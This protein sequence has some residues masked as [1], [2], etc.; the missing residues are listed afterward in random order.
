MIGIMF[1]FL[2]ALITGISL[3]LQKVSLIKINNWKQAITSPKWLFSISLNLPAFYFFLLAL[4]IERLIII[5]PIT[6]ASL[7]VTVLLEIIILKYKMNLYEVSAIVLFLT[8][9][10]FITDTFCS[11]FNMICW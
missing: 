4:K 7:F 8:G 11:I 2:S 3:F 10:L 6:Y 9:A 5:Q 1:A